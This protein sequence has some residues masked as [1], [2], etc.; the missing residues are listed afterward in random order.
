MFLDLTTKANA[1]KAK[2]NK[3]EYTKLNYFYSAQQRKQLTKWKGNL[4]NV[5]KHLQ[6][7][8][9]VRGYYPKYL[10]NSYNSIVKK[11]KKNPTDPI[12][13]KGRGSK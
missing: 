6:T 5:R 2:I 10:K 9:L 13:K 12:K 8:Y 7:I 11:K 4:L 3:W 1:A